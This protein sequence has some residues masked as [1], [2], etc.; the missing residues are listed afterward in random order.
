MTVV[1]KSVVIACECDYCNDQEDESQSV[2][3]AEAARI[4]LA[5]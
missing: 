3:A 1:F 5:A 2:Q 4:H